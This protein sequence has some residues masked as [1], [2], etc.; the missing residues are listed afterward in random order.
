MPSD[1]KL[2]VVSFDWGGPS[3]SKGGAL[4]S[5][6][7]TLASSELAEARDFC[8]MAQD[9][10]WVTSW[11]SHRPQTV[12]ERME[13]IS[14]VAQGFRRMAQDFNCAPQGHFLPQM[15]L[16][17]SSYIR[18]LSLRICHASSLPRKSSTTTVFFSSFL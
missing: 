17:C 2:I 1:T 5:Y 11:D 4:P 18:R 12:S 9:F 16:K 10:C 6:P 13:D 15:S 3:D 7:E 14:G 8:G